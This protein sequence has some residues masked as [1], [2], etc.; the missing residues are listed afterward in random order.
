MKPSAMEAQQI[1][2][3]IKPEI[4]RSPGPLTMLIL[5]APLL[6]I[7]LIMLLVLW[8]QFRCTSL[9]VTGEVVKFKTGVLSTR[10]R[11]L[12]LSD[13]RAV[14]VRQ[15]LIQRMMDSGVVMISSAATAGATI[16][17]PSVACWDVKLLIDGL[18]REH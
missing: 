13:I 3:I 1:Y 2:Q 17:I 5:L 8:I 14:D 16:Q 11:E 6:G 10:H 18:R 7:S 15:G 12:R 9:T 4:W